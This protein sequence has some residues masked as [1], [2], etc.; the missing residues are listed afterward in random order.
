[1][2]VTPIMTQKALTASMEEVAPMKKAQQS[3]SEVIVME[4][5]ACLRPCLNLSEA[6]MS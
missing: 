2:I 6:G 1:M 3:V 4:G 5:P